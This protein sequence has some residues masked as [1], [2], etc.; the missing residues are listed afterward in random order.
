MTEAQRRMACIESIMQV[1]RWDSFSQSTEMEVR[2]RC[3]GRLLR[4]FG[5]DVYGERDPDKMR[6]ERII[7]YEHETGKADYALFGSDADNA[8][9]SK[10]PLVALVEVK[11]P[12]NLKRSEDQCLWYARNAGGDILRMVVVTDGRRWR[13]YDAL[14]DSDS[15]DGRLAHENDLGKDTAK[16]VLRWF[17]KLLAKPRV[18]RDQHVKPLKAL[19]GLQQDEDSLSA[20]DHD[21]A[22]DR[23]TQAPESKC[24][25]TKKHFILK[26][27]GHPAPSTT[28]GTRTIRAI[29]I[30]I[31]KRHGEDAMQAV[32]ANM[33]AGFILDKPE[34]HA[35]R[36]PKATYKERDIG[37]GQ[38]VFLEGL[39]RKKVI[40]WA[41][42]I[43][44]AAG[45][46]W[47]KDIM[48]REGDAVGTRSQAS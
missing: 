47:G 33:R 45:L 5:W 40:P 39:S 44:E 38:Y 3:V 1:V 21:C 27:D 28:Q 8:S 36:N 4:S 23:P 9:A 14:A 48:V 24:A 29:L 35:P 46:Q 26:V 43:T 37:G 34:K 13:F 10:R 20:S 17:S 42:A 16:D 15:A 2:D 30:W 25:N 11:R 7:T 31:R 32:Q 6:C 22:D 18:V 41:R 19:W 12:G